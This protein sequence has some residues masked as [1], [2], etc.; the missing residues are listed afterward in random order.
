MGIPTPIRRL[1]VNTGPKVSKG[2][3]GIGYYQKLRDIAQAIWTHSSDYCRHEIILNQKTLILNYG[4]EI[5][6]IKHQVL[7]NIN[8]IP[9]FL[10]S[11]CIINLM[12]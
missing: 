1:L 4:N 8:I 5:S 2:G 6:G 3:S 12:Y 10:S 11:C 7:Y 9:H